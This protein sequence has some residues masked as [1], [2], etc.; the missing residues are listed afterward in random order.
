MFRKFLVRQFALL[1]VVYLCSGCVYLIVGG[2][3]A[4]GGYVVSPDTV[5]G[6]TNHDLDAVW[7]NAVDVIGI[8]GTIEEQSKAGGILIAHVNGCKV[9]VTI[10]TINKNNVKVNV[11]ARK[12]FF[13]KI[14]VAQDVFVKIMSTL[15][16]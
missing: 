4:L 14:T 3:G 2:I 12:T 10:S 5:E 7:D 8:M 16:E 11:K 6:V 9:T 15:N 1:S 13:P